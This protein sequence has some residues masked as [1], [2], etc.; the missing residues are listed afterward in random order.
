MTIDVIV[1]GL[2]G[3][4]C[5]SLGNCAIMSTTSCPL[6]TFPKIA[7]FPSSQG[8]GAKV[9]KN[10]LPPVFGPEFAIES[11]P[12]ALCFRSGWNSSRIVYPGPPVPVPVGSPPWIMN[13]GITL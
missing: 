7:C 6:M 5:A 1:T 10:W 13:P 12:F 8:V 11:I 2:F 4:S 3:L 9:M